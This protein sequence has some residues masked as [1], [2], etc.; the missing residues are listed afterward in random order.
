M[1]S[2][3][4]TL[5]DF[6]QVGLQICQALIALEVQNTYITSLLPILHPRIT[7][8]PYLRTLLTLIISTL[9]IT[10]VHTQEHRVYSSSPQRAETTKSHKKKTTRSESSRRSEK[11]KK[12]SKNKKRRDSD[13]NKTGLG[14]GGQN[15]SGHPSIHRS[16]TPNTPTNPYYESN[17][18][19]NNPHHHESK[20]SHTNRRN[21]FDLKNNNINSPIP[22]I[23]YPDL[24][25][26][27]LSHSPNPNNPHIYGELFQAQAAQGQDY[28]PHNGNNHNNTNGFMTGGVVKGEE[29]IAKFAL[30]TP[31]HGHTAS[32]WTSQHQSASEGSESESE[33]SLESSSTDTE[34]SS[35][36]S[37]SYDDST[38]ESDSESEGSENGGNRVTRV[39]S[40]HISVISTGP[41][42]PLK[43]SLR[44]PR[45]SPLSPSPYHSKPNNLG[46]RSILRSPSAAVGSSYLSQAVPR[47]PSRVRIL[48]PNDQSSPSSSSSSTSSDSSSDSESDSGS[49]NSDQ[50]SPPQHHRRLNNPSPRGRAGSSTNARLTVTTPQSHRASPVPNSLSLSLRTPE[51]APVR[52]GGKKQNKKFTK[53]SQNVQKNVTT[54]SPVPRATRASSWKKALRSLLPSSNSNT[55]TQQVVSKPPTPQSIPQ[56]HKDFNQNKTVESEKNKS[57]KKKKN[58]KDFDFEKDR[59]EMT[60]LEA[61]Q[62]E[63]HKV[64]KNKQKKKKKSKKKKKEKKKYQS[65]QEKVKS[66][67]ETERENHVGLDRAQSQG[68]NKSDRLDR[69]A[70]PSTPRASRIPTPLHS[71]GKLNGSSVVQTQASKWA[72][73]TQS[74][75]KVGADQVLQFFQNDTS[76]S[77]SD[78]SL[79]SPRSPRGGNG[80]VKCMNLSVPASPHRLT[81]PTEAELARVNRST[82][83]RKRQQQQTQLTVEK[84][85][86]ER[87]RVETVVVDQH[88]DQSAQS[89]QSSADSNSDSDEHEHEKSHQRIPSLSGLSLVSLDL[90]SD[91]PSVSP[92]SKS[93]R[94]SM[95]F[96][97]ASLSGYTLGSGASDE[98]DSSDNDSELE[99]EKERER[100]LEQEAERQMQLEIE[101]EIQRQE[102][103]R[104]EK[105]KREL[106]EKA[107]RDRRKSMR[108]S[109][110][111][112]RKTPRKTPL[113][114]SRNTPRKTPR[115]TPL[116]E[117]RKTESEA[118]T[119]L[120]SPQVIEKQREQPS[121][122]IKIS[123]NERSERHVDA[124][125]LNNLLEDHEPHSPEHRIELALFENDQIKSQNKTENES[126]I[127]LSPLALAALEDREIEERREQ[128]FGNN[129]SNSNRGGQQHELDKQNGYEYDHGHG[130]DDVDVENHRPSHSPQ[131]IQNRQQ[132]P[133]HSYSHNEGEQDDDDERRM[134]RE[135]ES[136]MD[137]KQEELEVMSMTTPPRQRE[138]VRASRTSDTPKSSKKKAK[139]AHSQAYTPP[140]SFTATAS[141]HQPTASS[142]SRAK[143]SVSE[144][145]TSQL[146]LT[147]V[148]HKS[149]HKSTSSSRRSSPVPKSINR[150]TG[151]PSSSRGA[152]ASPVRD[153]RTAQNSS[154]ALRGGSKSQNR[155]SVNSGR[156]L[157]NSTSRFQSTQA[158]NKQQKGENSPS[159]K[160]SSR[161]N[162]R[163]NS[164][165]LEKWKSRYGAH[166]P[167]KRL[168]GLIPVPA[169]RKMAAQQSAE[170]KGAST[171]KRSSLNVSAYSILNSP[172]GISRLPSQTGSLK[173]IRSAQAGYS[174]SPMKGHHRAISTSS[175]RSDSSSVHMDEISDMYGGDY[176]MRR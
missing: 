152:R 22:H 1:P 110:R 89:D 174:A 57:K 169:S 113:K 12:S 120:F 165:A 15:G 147:Y 142:S 8:I 27:A 25:S 51:I 99:R 145:L 97:R 109:G 80:A 19:P 154:P 55:P 23:S 126:K 65:R 158:L 136:Y 38:S 48:D 95:S 83:D 171:G 105:E 4:T 168:T 63:S 50:V 41:K 132:S 159:E 45:R 141:H 149:T 92:S 40:D 172:D 175:I 166:T 131:S 59:D 76:N 61:Q 72:A 143:L 138:R 81:V 60:A 128:L 123:S 2:N 75:P 68:Q 106:E 54:D 125:P 112:P 130:Y 157:V 133:S 87:E 18:N 108:R 98:E 164:P 94:G 52:M 139:P 35:S 144:T 29:M 111:T 104:L 85:R 7:Q 118:K 115:K 77:N 153:R 21:I 156:K 134:R 9:M 102:T 64:H 49:G 53:N 129:H 162:S 39:P 37:S 14:Y 96:S 28:H 6:A 30:R 88:R 150:S 90:P 122:S 70:E 67:A 135:V 34:S 71:K 78:P 114:S 5:E 43:S 11:R 103:L 16:S 173:S 58:K 116:K 74:V 148:E 127:P 62:A 73:L 47:T 3:N 44:S 146:L 46:N 161:T 124:H 32:E 176:S 66:V 101:K 155:S 119:R 140:S 91:L 82:V 13:K 26:P 79:V 24:S 170:R 163:T 56:Y 160:K 31:R 20:H 93:R 151:S 86:H 100:E 69:R 84:E 107:E 121:L 117:Q 10:L 17:N 42:T 137:E 36:Q 167:N 33:S